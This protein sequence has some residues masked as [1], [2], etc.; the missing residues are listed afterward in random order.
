MMSRARDGL[1]GLKG[2]TSAY[3]Y[4]KCQWLR[5]GRVERLGVAREKRDVKLTV[6]RVDVG[7]SR[8]VYRRLAAAKPFLT[9]SLWVRLRSGS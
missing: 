8:I 3:Q 6:C 1:V 7:R 9:V 5:R 4:T 2:M